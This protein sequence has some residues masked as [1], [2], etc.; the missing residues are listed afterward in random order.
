MYCLHCGK[1]I[2]GNS[3][4]HDSG[5]H[6]KCIRTFFNTSALPMLD[7]TDEMIEFLAEESTRSGY[8]IPGV[9]KKLSLNLSTERD[10]RLTI[11]D[12]PAGFILKPQTKEY[13]F[14]PEAEDIIMRF[15][16]SSGIPTVPHALIRM[17]DNGYGYISRRIDRS[18]PHVPRLTGSVK[19][20]AMEDFC[21]LEERLTEDKY[22]GSYERCAAVIR[23]FSDR[24]G[25]DLAELFIRIVFCFLTG[26]SDMHLKNFSLIETEP[27]SRRFILSPAYDL[28]PVNLLLPEDKD[29]TALT[30]NGK[31]RN[32]LKKDFL[33]FASHCGLTEKTAERLID[34]LVADIPAWEQLCATSF[35]P[36]D[37]KDSLISLIHDRRAVFE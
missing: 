15:A 12:R 27:G 2:E 14:L 25:L 6:G 18:F 32:I 28:L 11:H 37:I 21:Q 9:Q 34:K 36:E 33:A 3:S 22:R 24:P 23:T 31:K 5:W 30:L 35:L 1:A 4:E 8:T 29:Q 13:P 17:N 10:I 7:A 26:N 19:K 20:Y 16:D